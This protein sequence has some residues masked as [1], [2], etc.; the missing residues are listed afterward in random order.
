MYESVSLRQ[1]GPGAAA[2]LGVRPEAGVLAWGS[3]L[4]IGKLIYDG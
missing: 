2:G 3:G 4:G 1:V